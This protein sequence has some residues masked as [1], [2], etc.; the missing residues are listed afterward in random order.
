MNRDPEILFEDEHYVVVNKPRGLLVHRSPIDKHETRFAL[1][2]V[3]D[4]I[5]Q[6]VYPVHRL[7]KPTSG[8]LVFGKSPEAARS[9]S[10]NWD[11]VRKVYIALV[12]GHAP[13]RAFIDHAIREKDP[14]VRRSAEGDAA[15]Q[16]AQTRVVCLARGEF[17][18]ALERY[19][20][21]R[22]SLVAAMPLTGR[23]HQIRRHLK[24][25]S[26]PI[27]GD[28]KHGKGV[29]N[30]YFA[31]QLGIRGLYLHALVIRFRHP[32]TGELVKCRAEPD[33]NWERALEVFGWENA[34]PR[35]H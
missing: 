18:I 25:I 12:R 1:Q 9:L 3:R 2:I 17:P 32:F 7:D 34:L 10:E 30:R 29:H 20:V 5:G 21:S 16:A 13:Q 33:T 11:S 24:H 35:A 19:A 22:Y 26:H 14:S 8:T 15:A 28:A 23:R 4:M 31:E 6:R 27:I